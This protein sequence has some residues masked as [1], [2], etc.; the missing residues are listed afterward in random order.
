MSLSH[1]I[2]LLG[3]YLI[4]NHL[5]E[6]GSQTSFLFLEVVGVGKPGFVS[7]TKYTAKSNKHRSIS[8]IIDNMHYV[9]FRI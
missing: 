4:T 2:E 9:N 6:I 1:G 5:S 7:L 3:C 8:F